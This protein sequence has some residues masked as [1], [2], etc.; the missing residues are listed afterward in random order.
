MFVYSSVVFGYFLYLDDFATALL[1]RDPV[2]SEE[3][4]AKF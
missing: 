1:A 3:I 4:L 2:R